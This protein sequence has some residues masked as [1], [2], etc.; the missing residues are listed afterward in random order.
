M[1]AHRSILHYMGC[2]VGAGYWDIWREASG[3]GSALL[4]FELR[5]SLCRS[6]V[7]GG[8]Y[9]GTAELI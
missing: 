2:I 7:L 1:L 9:L 4:W 3:R 8:E 6:E 5:G